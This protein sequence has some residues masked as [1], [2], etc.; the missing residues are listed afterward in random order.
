MSNPRSP[1]R[2]A[3]QLI[4]LATQMLHLAEVELTRAEDVDVPPAPT[5]RQTYNPGGVVTAVAAV[6]RR[7]GLHPRMDGQGIVDAMDASADLL[8]A[9]G[10]EPLE[11]GDDL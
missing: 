4:H 11:G 6:L 1:L 9:L 8:R 2:K 10:V 3:Y 7:E 5:T